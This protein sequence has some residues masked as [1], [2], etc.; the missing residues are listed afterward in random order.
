MFEFRLRVLD[1][2][3][4]QTDPPP[5]FLGV[6]EGVP[7]VVAHAAAAAEAGNELAAALADHFV[8]IQG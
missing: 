3:E 2:Q 6:V 8:W 4:P 7:Q 1:V 5:T